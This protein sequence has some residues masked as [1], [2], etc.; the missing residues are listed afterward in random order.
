MLS[1]KS[2]FD[3]TILRNLL[4]DRFFFGLIIL[5][6]HLF[7]PAYSQPQ[8]FNTEAL[9]PGLYARL[10]TPRGS[11]L[12]EL[13]YERAPLTVTAFVGLAEGSLTN[14][15][16]S[17]SE[18]YYDGL[19]FHRVVPDFVVQ[20]G[21]PEGTGEGG[22]G[23]SF[24]DEFHPELQHGEPGMVSMANS[25][26]NTNG[27]Q[28]FITLDARQDRLNYK[29]SVFGKVRMGMEYIRNIQEDD[30][31]DSLEIIRVGK[32]AEDFQTGEEIWKQRLEEFPVIPKA[33][34]PHPYFHDFGN[35]D[36]PAW[37]PRWIAEKLYH[38]EIIQGIA[39]YLRTFHTFLPAD[40]SDTPQAFAQRFLE[41][42]GAAQLQ[43]QSQA[44][45]ILYFSEQDSWALYGSPRIYR[46]LFPGL[47]SEPEP[48]DWERLKTDLLQKARASFES[49]NPRRMVDGMATQVLLQLDQAELGMDD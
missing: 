25:G 22:P 23:F 35:L 45:V 46:L 20:G 32:D 16:R 29:H 44:I 2:H 40:P 36:F 26:P 15:F 28:F 4:G 31:I 6:I 30:T 34:V 3:L 49:P 27:S 38:Y 12:I 21:D 48:E 17:P 47:D 41:M 43:D 18:P 37:F 14:T 19:T 9:E 5:G 10:E 1:Q 13:F 7:H 39:V 42:L 24:P 33:P 11:V 8:E